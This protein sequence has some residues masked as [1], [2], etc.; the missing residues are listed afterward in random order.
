[1]STL[2]YN[3]TFSRAVATLLETRNLIEENRIL[4]ERSESKR[5]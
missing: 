3:D 1:M 5:D 4:R 2:P